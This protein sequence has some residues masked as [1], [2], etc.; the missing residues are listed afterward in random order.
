M[1][2]SYTHQNIVKTHDTVSNTTELCSEND[3]IAFLP[4]TSESSNG[5]ASP[6]EQTNQDM[7][8]LDINEVFTPG[9]EQFELLAG[10]IQKLKISI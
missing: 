6:R 1:E 10:Q 4:S 5:V 7:N 8:N 3:L 2:D 9:H